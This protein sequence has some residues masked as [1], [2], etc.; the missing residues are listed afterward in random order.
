[1]AGGPAGGTALAAAAPAGRVFKSSSTRKPWVTSGQNPRSRSHVAE[2]TKLQARPTAVGPSATGRVQDGVR[3]VAVPPG[4]AS[5]P[6]ERERMARKHQPDEAN[7]MDSR[8][9]RHCE[10]ATTVEASPEPARVAAGHAAA[11]S[12]GPS[13]NAAPLPEPRVA[14][15]ELSVKQA[16]PTSIQR[17]ETAVQPGREA[18]VSA[19]RLASKA[20]APEPESRQPA[21]PNA[22]KMERPARAV[23]PPIPAD[24]PP[25]SMRKEA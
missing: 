10:Q 13:A 3:P 2:A 11:A 17:V 9:E 19:E 16:A 22:P 12:S 5:S 1:M 6:S 25:R 4:A 7:G 14:G 21:V 20:V 15:V 24:A 23:P 18:P 8:R